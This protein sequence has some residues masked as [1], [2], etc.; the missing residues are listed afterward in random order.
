MINEKI[1]ELKIEYLNGW[2]DF[3]YIYGI[4]NYFVGF[5]VSYELIL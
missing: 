4:N 2:F 1:F 3:Y 5:F